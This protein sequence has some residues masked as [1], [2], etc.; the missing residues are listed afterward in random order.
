MSGIAF[1]PSRFYD[2]VVQCLTEM[3]ENYLKA[4]DV[5]ELYSNGGTPGIECG[6]CQHRME[7]LSATL[8]DPQP[9]MS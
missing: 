7:V 8:M 3:C 4:I 2:A 6:L 9:E 5:T 1:E